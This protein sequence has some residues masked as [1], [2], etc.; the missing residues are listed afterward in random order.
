VDKE[1]RDRDKQPEGEAAVL[2]AREAMSLISP[3][4]GHGFMPDLSSLPDSEASGSASGE[5]SVTS[6]DRSEHFESRD[7][8]SSQT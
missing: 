6:E 1:K 5:E 4:P 3:V 7:S 2:P 8:A